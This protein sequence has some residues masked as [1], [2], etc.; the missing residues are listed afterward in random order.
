M[1]TN[2][3]SKCVNIVVIVSVDTV[4]ACSEVEEIG[5]GEI[6]SLSLWQA[7][8]TNLIGLDDND[9]LEV[10]PLNVLLWRDYGIPLTLNL[11]F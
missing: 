8:Q 4:E 5:E 7:I 3:S 2:D 9:E 1:S 10:A 6:P 11:Y